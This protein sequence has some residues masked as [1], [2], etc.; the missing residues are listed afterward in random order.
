M[1]VGFNPVTAARDVKIEK[2]DKTCKDVSAS[3]R[4]LRGWVEERY[5]Q[6]TVVRS[7]L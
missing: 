3:G 7:T 4:E 5:G 6:S 2:W 1:L